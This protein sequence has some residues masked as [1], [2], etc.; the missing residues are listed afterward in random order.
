MTIAPQD[1]YDTL[2]AHDGC[3]PIRAQDIDRIVRVLN[4][5][6]LSG[7]RVRLPVVL[8]M[9]DVSYE[10]SD[11]A[12]PTLLAKR[13]GASDDKSFALDIPTSGKTPA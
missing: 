7:D 10:H 9:P 6:R 2:I 4:V 13:A 11:A 8:D 1:V 12:T 3:P 5:H